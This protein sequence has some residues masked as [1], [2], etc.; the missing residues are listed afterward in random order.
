MRVE[1][2]RSVLKLTTAT[3]WRPSGKNIHRMPDD[4]PDAEWGVTPDQGFEVKMDDAAYKTWRTYRLRRDLIGDGVDAAL[5]A[6]LSNEDGAVPED[7]VDEMVKRAADY[8]AE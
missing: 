3:Y 2:G 8:L 4:G 5:A 1:S 6:E 7:Y